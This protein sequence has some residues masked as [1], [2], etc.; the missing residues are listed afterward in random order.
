MNILTPYSEEEFEVPY[1]RHRI[2][3]NVDD[4][5]TFPVQ[6]GLNDDFLTKVQQRIKIEVISHEK[7]VV[8]FV[9]SEQLYG[10]CDARASL[11]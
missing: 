2:Y 7:G 5:F 3:P 10:P 9:S 1:E 4:I 11:F 6:I 8:S